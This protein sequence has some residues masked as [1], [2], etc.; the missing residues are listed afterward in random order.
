[1]SGRGIIAI[2]GAAASGKS[3]LARN[4]A[5]RLQLPYVNTGLM[6]RALTLEAL[7]R[8]TDPGNGPAL[9]DLM[10]T[11][12]FSVDGTDPAELWIDG[13]PPTGSL[14]DEDVEAAVSQVASHPG[15]RALMRDVQR[16]LGAAGA[17]MEGRDIGSVVFPEAALKLYLTADA[18]A[19]AERRIEER[20]DAEG[21]VTGD[22]EQRDAADGQVN[23][24]RP[25][26]H[27]VTLDTTTLDAMGTLAEAIAIVERMAPEL[28]P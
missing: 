8:G 4:L 26:E 6:Y 27:A 16:S 28:L 7:R 12:S 1:M 13:S 22:L 15:V 23:P 3:T 10:R 21:R 18:S 17:V 14:N 9:V 19:R 2:D 25:A 11:L 20:V 5:R 24:F